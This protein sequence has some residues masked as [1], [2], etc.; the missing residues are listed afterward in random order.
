M[1]KRSRKYKTE[2]FIH[3]AYQCVKST[4]ERRKN[5]EMHEGCG[6]W[7]VTKSKFANDPLYQ[8]PKCES[9]P[10]RNRVPR[11]RQH[12]FDTAIEARNFK[13]EKN[14]D[15]HLNMTSEIINEAVRKNEHRTGTFWNTSRGSTPR[16]DALFRAQML[17]REYYMND[18]DIY[19]MRI[20][21][22][23]SLGFEDEN[24]HF[25]MKHLKLPFDCSQWPELLGWNC[26]NERLN[27]LGRSREFLHWPLPK[28]MREKTPLIESHGGAV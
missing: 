21:E 7:N 8:A 11:G 9:C 4:N 26:P 20:N 24:I 17:Q 22:G 1:N 18:M 6:R 23:V 27:F 13:N 25:I 10:K 2:K 5:T 19:L 3:F 12:R 15:L 16:E 28:A 14:G